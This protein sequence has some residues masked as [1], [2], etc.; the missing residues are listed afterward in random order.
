[1]AF[2]NA[3][4]TIVPGLNRGP[5]LV[6]VHDPTVVAATIAASGNGRANW[7]FSGVR[8]LPRLNVP[9]REKTEDDYAVLLR[10]NSIMGVVK[11]GRDRPANE[12]Q[13]PYGAVQSERARL[14]NLSKNV[15]GAVLMAI[16]S[17]AVQLKRLAVVNMGHPGDP[18]G[19]GGYYDQTKQ[20]AVANP[21]NADTT[22]REVGIPMETI[23]PI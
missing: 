21:S 11:N 17:D 1:M 2:S 8:A 19:R 3:K 20:A 15:I 6:I 12:L 23:W 9:L 4:V 13:V 7:Y 22:M 10:Y 5:A 16:G 14:N 18:T